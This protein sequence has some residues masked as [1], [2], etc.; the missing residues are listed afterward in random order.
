MKDFF[1]SKKFKILMAVAALLIGFMIY[2]AVNIDWGHFGSDAIGA[3]TA[4][5]QKL[6]ATISKAAN[7]FFDRFINYDKYFKEN[8][9]LRDKVN[10][11][12][13][14]LVDYEELQRENEQLREILGLKEEHADF[15]FSAPADVIGRE[16]N[17]PFATFTI[18]KG[19]LHGLELYDPVI[20]KDGLVGWISEVSYTSA[21][22]CTILNPEMKIGC[23]DVE[24]AE[25]GVLKGDPELAEE[26]RVRL[27]HLPRNADTVKPGATIATSGTSGLFPK[28][29]VVGEVEQVHEDEQGIS[30][31]AVVKPACNVAEIN[32]VF[33]LTDFFG[34]VDYNAQDS[35]EVGE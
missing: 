26:G 35:G 23:Y 7:D 6:S 29:L 13:G 11:L 14:K 12:T 10:E 25:I 32:S 9:T 17:D 34:K 31:Y 2:A 16:P 28:G 1:S 18:D 30:M 24:S 8:Q 20:T 19:S 22:V 33:V 15:E 4:P 27:A 21:K 5:F 3:I